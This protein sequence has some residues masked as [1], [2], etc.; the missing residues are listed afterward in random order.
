MV[1]KVAI[2]TGGGRG[3]GRA[4]A[5]E[6]ADAGYRVTIAARTTAELHEAAETIRARG[7]T[8]LALKTDVA[9]EQDIRHMVQGTVAEFGRIDV[10]INNAAMTHRGDVLTVSCDEWNRVLATNLTSYFLCTKYTVPHL[11]E[12][13]GGV[14]VNVSSVTANRGTGHGLAYAACKGAIDS[15]TYEMAVHLGPKHIRVISLQPGAIDTE[16]SRKYSGTFDEGARKI[17]D[18]SID[19]TPLGRWGTPEEIG[20]IIRFLVSDDASFITNTTILADGGWLRQTFPRS[21]CEPKA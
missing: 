6:L 17:T 20:R 14:V 15:M 21:L 19:M 5:I 8:V 18:F 3:I 2:V 4:A 13:G 16:I 12:A 7:G 11:I 1:D 10:L 9:I